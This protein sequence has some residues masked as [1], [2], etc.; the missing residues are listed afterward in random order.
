MMRRAGLGEV[1]HDAVD[2]L[3]HQVHVDRHARMRLDR[4]ADQRADREIRHVVVVHHVEMDQVGAGGDDGAH[5][6]A[7]PREVGGQER[8]RDAVGAC[9]RIGT[10]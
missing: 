3:H 6:F 9:H 1:R 4:R 7:E 5:F 10:V 2:R 8:G